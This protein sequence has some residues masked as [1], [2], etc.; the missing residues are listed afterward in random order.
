[1]AKPERSVDARKFSCPFCSAASSIKAGD[2]TVSAGNSGFCADSWTCKTCGSEN[3]I[4]DDSEFADLKASAP[5]SDLERAFRFARHL[6]QKKEFKKA[7]EIL[8]YILSQDKGY[9]E[10]R[11]VLEKVEKMVQLSQHAPR[12]NIIEVMYA[13]ED[14]YG[15]MLHFL[16]R[17]TGRI[18]S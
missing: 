11:L 17:K 4:F 13:M 10:C 15:E 6:A 2:V 8:H 14:N 7:S 3:V 18:T 16:S 9:H 12:I 5:A 1:M